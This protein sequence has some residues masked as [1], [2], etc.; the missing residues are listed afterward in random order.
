M[1]QKN[2]RALGTEQVVS[3]SPGIMLDTYSMFMK[4][5]ILGFIRGSLG[6]YDSIDAIIEFKQIC[7][8]NNSVTEETQ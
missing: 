8:A 5:A 3:L 4:P 7:S 2:R 1:A 6:A